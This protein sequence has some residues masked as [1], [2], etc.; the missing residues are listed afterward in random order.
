MQWI[1]QIFDL[2][3]PQAVLGLDL[4]H[5]KLEQKLLE[6]NHD[7]RLNPKWLKS[8]SRDEQLIQMQKLKMFKRFYLIL[9]KLTDVKLKEAN[10][11]QKL[12]LELI[13]NKINS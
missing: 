1:K 11:W 8:N 3:L 2:K 7:R 4:K 5:Q 6:A 13:H 12:Y 9:W 10:E